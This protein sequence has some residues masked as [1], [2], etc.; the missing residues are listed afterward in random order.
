MPDDSLRSATHGFLGH[1]VRQVL[2]PNVMVRPRQ[3]HPSE[4]QRPQDS[5][6]AVPFVALDEEASRGPEDAPH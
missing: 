5:G 3:A 1:L 2:V 6:A 4:M